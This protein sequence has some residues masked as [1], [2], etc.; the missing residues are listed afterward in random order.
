MGVAASQSVELFKPADTSVPGYPR[1]FCARGCVVE[2][3]GVHQVFVG[4]TLVGEYDKERALERNILLV[5]LAEDPKCHLEKLALAFGVSSEWVRR[6]R[7][8]YEQGGVEALGPR[9]GGGRSVLDER[10]QARLARLF[11]Q[12]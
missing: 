5:Q 9:E 4:G 1:W 11:A 7:R 2:R 3:D 6:L 10:D 12:G 8:R